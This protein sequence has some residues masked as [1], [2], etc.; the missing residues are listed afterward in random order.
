MNLD[1]ESEEILADRARRWGPL[2]EPMH[3]GVDVNGPRWGENAYLTFWDP[4]ADTYGHVH[5]MT[6]P[7]GDGRRAR[8]AAVVEGHHFEYNEPLPLLTAESAL[9]EFRSERVRAHLSGQ[10]VAAGTEFGVDLRYEPLRST[11]ADYTPGG[12][13]PSLQ[14][15]KP[16]QHFQQSAR[17]TGS[18]TVDGNTR[19]INGCGVRDR[20]WGFRDEAASWTEYYACFAIFDDFDIAVMKYLSPHLG[21]R[22]D[23]HLPGTGRQVTDSEAIRDSAA[24]LHGLNLML[25]DGSQLKIEDDGPPLARIPVRMGA[26]GVSTPRFGAYD[27]VTYVRTDSGARGIGTLQQGYLLTL[28]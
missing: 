6:S 28:R 25:D 20:T 23:G 13:L 26:E 12:V 5:V 27:Q 7:N 18:I 21:A 8:V 15:T 19:A 17:I 2:A 3:T 4:Q 24:E 1:L 14:G 10:I 9:M 22:V 16:L 11:K